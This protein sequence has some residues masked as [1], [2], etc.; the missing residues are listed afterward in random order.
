MRCKVFAALALAVAPLTAFTQEATPEAIDIPVDI[1]QSVKDIRVPH[2][3]AQGELSLRL[4]AAQA[5]R[6]SSTQFTFDDLRIEIFDAKAEEP[7]LE[8]LLPEAVFDQNTRRLISDRRSVIKGE[9]VEIVGRQLEFD[10]DS[11]TS[12]LRGPVTMVVTATD[13]IQP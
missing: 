12:R 13:T 9:T 5:E 2:H 6:S 7:A 1:G 10:I 4:I 3:N 8:V 11:R